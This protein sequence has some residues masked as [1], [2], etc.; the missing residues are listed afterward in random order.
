MM[1]EVGNPYRKIP[2][3]VGEKGEVCVCRRSWNLT[4]LQSRILRFTANKRPKT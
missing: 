1:K 4:T 2:V 3:P